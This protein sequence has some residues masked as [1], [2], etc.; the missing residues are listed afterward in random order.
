MGAAMENKI[1][2][3]I[4]TVSGVDIYVS[5]YGQF[6]AYTTNDSDGTEN[7]YTSETLEG[8]KE[9]LAKATKQGKSK[10][11][12]RVSAVRI[13]SQDAPTVGDI[14]SLDGRGLPRFMGSVMYSFEG[15]Y[16]RNDAET[17]PLVALH[18]E[19]TEL[20]KRIVAEFRRLKTVLVQVRPQDVDPSL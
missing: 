8:L 16:H 9:K 13:L 5:E 12:N 1:E 6:S 4:T 18:N 14:T 19:R 2:S 7:K 10:K 11:Y 17:A 3:L 15:L 20:Q